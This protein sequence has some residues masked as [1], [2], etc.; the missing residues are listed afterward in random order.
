MILTLKEL[1]EHLKLND[2]TVLRMLKNGQIEGAKVGGQ[3]RFNGS[4]IDKLFF[5]Q[6]V[7]EDDVPL[8]ELT[9]SR[10]EIPISRLIDDKRVF[11]DMKATNVDEAIDE[12]T[13][14]A[15]FNTLVLDINDLR[16]KCRAREKLLSTG[17][18]NGIA[19]PHPRDPITALRAP[20]CVVIGRSKNGVEYNAADD[21][22]VH[23]FFLI[24]SQTIELHLHLI[25]KIANLV[26]DAA[27]MKV[28]KSA[29]AP[30]DVI[31]GIMTHE[32]AEF[33][34]VSN[35]SDK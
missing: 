19:V 32:R 26:R 2:R 28:M 20:G 1:A 3:W 21:K 29:K 18:G 11:L 15:L 12:L 24:C 33:L 4:Q 27:F 8:E 6:P 35:D 14:P 9:H 34:N 25:G 22:P 23:Y 31:T 17:I 10:F 30:K 16:E 7:S 13:D 5:Q